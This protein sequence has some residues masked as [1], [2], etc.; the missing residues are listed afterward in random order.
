[1]KI[2]SFYFHNTIHLYEAASADHLFHFQVFVMIA[3]DEIDLLGRG[4]FH[5]P[6]DLSRI[7]E[8][9]IHEMLIELQLDVVCQIARMDDHFRFH[10]SYESSY[11][12][13]DGHGSIRDMQ[14]QIFLL[15][16]F[17]WYIDSAHGTVYACL[18][19]FHCL[20]LEDSCFHHIIPETPETDGIYGKEGLFQIEQSLQVSFTFSHHP[21]SIPSSS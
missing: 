4:E 12:R 3:H 16:D 15:S 18:Q 5:D 9:F 2:M 21:S 1:M 13:V 20:L 7:T 10:F 11:G 14:N 8:K 19:F 17:L 6:Y